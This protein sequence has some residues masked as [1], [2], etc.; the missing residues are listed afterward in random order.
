MLAALLASL[1]SACGS[2]SK[3]ASGATPSGAYTATFSDLARPLNGSWTVTF[4]KGGSYQ[5]TSKPEGGL[6]I[7]KG[8]YYAGTTFVI[9]TVYP[10]ACGPVG[11]GV[12]TYKLSLT[13]DKLKFVRVTD[14]CTLRAQILG[15]TFT[16]G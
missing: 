15:H 14:A 11:G 10:G 8:S 2:S 1:L 16:K 3:S 4:G 6:A 9:K 13:G 5:V 7:G 12:G